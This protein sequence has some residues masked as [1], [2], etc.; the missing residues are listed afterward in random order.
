MLLATYVVTEVRDGEAASVHFVRASHH[1]RARDLVVRRTAIEEEVLSVVR[2]EVD[3]VEVPDDRF[4]RDRRLLERYLGPLGQF[5]PYLRDPC[6]SCRGTGRIIGESPAQACGA[7][8]G[9]GFR[10]SRA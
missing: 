1:S 2:L 7:C 4:A 6:R 9:T 8:G 3:P 5:S 10:R